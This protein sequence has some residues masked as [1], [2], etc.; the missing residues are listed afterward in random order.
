MS[1]VIS[2]QKSKDQKHSNAILL[3]PAPVRQCVARLAAIDSWPCFADPTTRI[4]PARRKSGRHSITRHSNQLNTYCTHKNHSRA[5][6]LR[7]I[8]QSSSMFQHPIPH[9]GRQSARTQRSASA[10]VAAR[11]SN[12]RIPPS[13]SMLKHRPPESSSVRITTFRIISRVISPATGVV[14]AGGRGGEKSAR[15]DMNPGS[16]D[17]PDTV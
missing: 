15:H 10:T 16:F 9:T 12:V 7:L 13:S 1:V 17:G 3:P 11:S 8:F 2:M 6:F 14:G 5:C 4:E